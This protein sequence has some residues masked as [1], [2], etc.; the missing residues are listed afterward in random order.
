MNFPGSSCFYFNLH[1][2]LSTADKYFDCYHSNSLK[3]FFSD[4]LSTLRFAWTAHHY[5][6]SL[7]AEFI[8]IVAIDFGKMAVGGTSCFCIVNSIGCLCPGDS[9]CG[10][11]DFCFI[12]HYLAGISFFLDLFDQIYHAA[13]WCLGQPLSIFIEFVFRPHSDFCGCETN[14]G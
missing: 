3:K 10:A 7:E 13:T 14:L 8:R 12:I 1:I 11:N 6:K 2:S 9:F 4:S 5:F